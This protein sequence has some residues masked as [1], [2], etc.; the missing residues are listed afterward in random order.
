MPTE[1][2]RPG[3]GDRFSEADN[4]PES[5]YA[6][7]QQR[8]IVQSNSVSTIGSDV[9]EQFYPHVPPEFENG[10]QNAD[11]TYIGGGHAGAG[12]NM[13][14]HSHNVT[15]SQKGQALKPLVESSQIQDVEGAGLMVKG[16]DNH[17]YYASRDEPSGN[18]QPNVVKLQ[19]KT[20]TQ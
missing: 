10:S 5:P 1:V 9:Y 16:L 8:R 11:L 6:T 3:G 20:S 15:H 2:G 13:R 14:G 19:P 7:A 17:F 18:V 12:F 4:R